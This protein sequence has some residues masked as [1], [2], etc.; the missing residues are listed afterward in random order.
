MKAE[1]PGGQRWM[2]ML[3]GVIRLA[4]QDALGVGAQL[5]LSVTLKDALQVHNDRFC[6]NPRQPRQIQTATITILLCRPVVG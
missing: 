1:S 5:F 6:V 2:L 4:D 3:A